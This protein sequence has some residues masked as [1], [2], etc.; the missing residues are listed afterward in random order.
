MKYE[1]LIKSIAN[2]ELRL[3]FQSVLDIHNRKICGIEMLVRWEHPELGV[4]LP[5]DFLPMAEV[6]NYIKEIDLW[7]IQNTLEALLQH[8]SRL[9]DMDVHINISA[10][11]LGDKRL[12]E[13][14][15]TYA[16]VL[17]KIQIVLEL[18]EKTDC[19]ISPETFRQLREM[20]IEFALDDFGIG[21]SWFS[22]LRAIHFKYIKIDKTL[23]QN[24]TQNLNDVLILKSIIAMG[25]RLEL[26]VIAEGIEKPEELA[27]LEA[28]GCDYLQG[29]LIDHPVAISDL[30]SHLDYVDQHIA[31][32]F[33]AQKNNQIGV[34]YYPGSRF[35]GQV[36]SDNEKFIN[37]SIQLADKLGYTFESYCTLTLGN[38]ISARDYQKYIEAF[39]KHVRTGNSVTERLELLTANREVMD[40]IIAIQRHGASNHSIVY[41]EFMATNTDNEAMLQ[42]GHSYAQAFYE[43]PSGMIILTED[44]RILKWNNS[45]RK[46][47]GY[48][49][50][51]VVKHNLIKLLA[52][53]ENVSDFALL[54]N[55]VSKSGFEESIL[56]NTTQTGEEIICRWSIRTL[57]DHVKNTKVFICMVNDMTEETARE[58]ELKKIR[59][60][61]DQSR[62]VIIITN[63]KGD[64]EYVNEMF[65]EVTGYS[66]EEAI[67]ANTRIMSS[68]EHTPSYYRTLWETISSGQ[69]WKGEFH[70]KKKDGSYYWCDATIYPIK[71]ND[72]TIGY[73]ELQ[74]DTTKQKELMTM[75]EDLRKRLFE[76]DRIASIGLLTSGI[77]HEINNPIGYIQG[78]VQYLLEESERILE[79]TQ[80]DKEDYVEALED[81]QSGVVQIRKIADGLKRY[82]FK[83]DISVVEDVDLFSSIQELLI[84]TKNEYKYHANIE[85]QRDE[86]KTYIVEGYNSKLK[87]VFM[88]LL[89]NATHAIKANEM[90]SMGKIQIVFEEDATTVSVK[91]IDDGCGMSAS[92]MAHMYDPLFTTK[93]AGI[94][95][96]LGL[97]ITKQLVE[98]EH[99][100]ILSCQS[101]EGKGTAFTVT[102]N[103]HIS[104]SYAQY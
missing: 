69:F 96:G 63:T 94:G 19:E 33:P 23:I 40:A 65:T 55:R 44:F 32:H 9:Y 86:D 52:T 104:S 59:K 2:N 22:R 27:L 95:T 99:G 64:I 49:K 18:S 93:E 54:F 102:L 79:F 78:N 62:S 66:F 1:K 21:Y 11:T 76:Q 8:M 61:L 34:S 26:K 7:V 71:E 6:G 90:E 60:A 13:V 82:L 57:Y 28:N 45:S 17:A 83:K 47:F 81:I 98:E 5:A 39:S 84:I 48:S 51:E 80:T 42:L 58:V 24:L 68:G 89:I 67:V 35:F 12:L 37:P 85:I 50:K 56:H 30:E 75:N 91:I 74:V 15:K 43:A 46:I 88:N 101:V 14:L 70:N 103:K 73:V 3:S 72:H 20:G 87:Q 10:K 41:I 29:F 97:S 53:E 16:S 100:G 31:A 38:L 4:V 36:V 25:S 92:V 77:I